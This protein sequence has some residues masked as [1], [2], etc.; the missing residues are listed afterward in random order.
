M[1]GGLRERDRK[2][3]KGSDSL[4]DIITSLHAKSCKQGNI[5]YQLKQRSLTISV[6]RRRIAH[7]SFSVTANDAMCFSFC[8]LSIVAVFAPPTWSQLTFKT[9]M[10]V[11]RVFFVV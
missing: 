3:F 5:S 6:N 4:R 7:R 9:L 11:G 1:A 2:T 8:S 10:V